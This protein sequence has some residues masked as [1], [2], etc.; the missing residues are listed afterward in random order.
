MGRNL[1]LVPLQP[2][3]HHAVAKPADGRTSA[4]VTAS[5]VVVNFRQ[6]EHTKRLLRQLDRCEAMR[7]G[8]A[9]V[10][11]VD[12]DADA[13]PLRRWVHHRPGVS[14]L[15]FGRNR[16]FARAVNEAARHA[17][18]EWLLLLNPDISIADEFLDAVIAS[19]QSR[20]LADPNVG[21]M[22]FSLRHADNS[23]QPSTGPFPTLANVLW[24]L[25][26]PRSR[27]RCRHAPD[28][29]AEVPW[30]TGCCL[31]VRRLCWDELDGC[32][33]D[34]FLYY[35]DVDLC[36]RGRA[37]GWTVWHEVSPSATHFH[38][39]HSRPV[40]PALRLI[41]RHALMTYAAKHWP[42]WQFSTLTRLIGWECRLRSWLL[43]DGSE[44]YQ[45]LLQIARL[46]RRG[47]SIR[48]RHLLAT[49]ARD[50]TQELA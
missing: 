36:R 9:E 50:L 44:H 23:P 21:I 12:N 28:M 30:A 40:L 17:R 10:V 49:S 20:C 43:R 13:G 33:E 11:V 39:L 24:G 4:A 42:R 32:D 41:T 14:I 1:T 19:A 46:I 7:T 37:A 15:S 29:P 2:D 22:G 38:P 8:A 47:E 18:G 48:A 3:L 16:G 34:F 5:I 31:L 25:I 45:R 27:R 35:E 6:V 26:K